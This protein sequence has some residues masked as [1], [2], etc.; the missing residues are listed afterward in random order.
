MTLVELEYPK[1]ER[2]EGDD[3]YAKF[4]C[5]PLPPGYG[6]TLGN[7]LR[8][9]LLS[10]L[11]G[12]AIT[13][14]RVRGVAH[15]FSTI[16]GVKEDVVQIVLNLKNVRLRSFANEPVTL[17]L[18]KEGP[19]VAT[20]GD[21]ATT[22]EIE[23]VN[24]ETPIATLEPEASLW[25][26][27]TVE[28]GKGF[29]SAERREGL[30]IGVIPIDAL[31]SP[32]RKVNFSVESTRVG[33]VTNYD[34]LILE[35]WTDATTTPDEAVAQGSKVLVDQFSLF[36]GLTRAQTAIVA[37]ERTNGSSLPSAIADMPIEDLDLPQRAFNSLKRHGITKVG[38]LLQTPDE[39][40]LRMRNFGKK[41]LD[42][43]KE[44]LAAR[45]LI[46]LPPRDES[47]EALA[48]DSSSDGMTDAEEELA[49]G[50]DERDES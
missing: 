6:T 13:S 15:E 33:Q 30:P 12:A 31:F 7:S 23:I 34:R 50:S 39:E 44:R 42:E 46:E 26:E 36:A 2:V 4:A 14:A 1:I 48:D 24:P 10:S 40:L 17:T 32:V 47:D 49:T 25:M 20:A 11:E 5:E 9:V 18:E 16:Q 27:L 21:I 38:Q 43:I 28:K 19:G 8:R 41:S 37:P 22:S 3:R 45:G 35:V 29:H